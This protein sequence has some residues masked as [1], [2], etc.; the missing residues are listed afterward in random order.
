MFCTKLKDLKI[1]AECPF[2]LLAPGQAPR[3]PAEEA[4]GSSESCEA[5]LPVCQ[6]VPEKNAQA[7]LPQRKTSRSRVYLHTLAESICKL[8]FPE[9]E[10]LNLALQRTL[11][12]HKI[13]ENRKSL[14]RDDF[15]K[16]IADQATVAGG[17][18]WRRLLCSWGFT[19]RE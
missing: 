3:E 5:T 18:H 16:I 9:F 15:E 7:G 6:D 12:K 4:A 14:E 10:R 2:S 13:K 11:A 19:Q 17:D 8:I 1:T